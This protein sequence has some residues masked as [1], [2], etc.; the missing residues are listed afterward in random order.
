M[1]CKKSKSH[2]SF[3][4]GRHFLWSQTLNFVKSIE[5]QNKNHNLVTLRTHICN[6]MQN[7]SIL[8]LC[9]WS[10]VTFNMCFYWLIY[11]CRLFV[12]CWVVWSLFIFLFFLSGLCLFGDW[13]AI[14]A[15]FMLYQLYYV[16]L[17]FWMSDK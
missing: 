2:R 11:F 9:L 3:R 8:F 12:Y 17:A 7:A 15:Q 4:K 6:H 14:E 16:W 1:L 5:K 10:F 13:I